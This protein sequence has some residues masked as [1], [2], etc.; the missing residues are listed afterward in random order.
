[1]YCVVLSCVA[2]SCVVWG[3]LRCVVLRCFVFCLVDPKP[4]PNPNHNPNN[5][6]FTRLSCLVLLIFSAGLHCVRVIKKLFIKNVAEIPFPIKGYKL[7]LI[8]VQCYA[9]IMLFIT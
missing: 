8:G 6:L 4:I 1:M 5:V 3:C 7:C 2:M 9:T